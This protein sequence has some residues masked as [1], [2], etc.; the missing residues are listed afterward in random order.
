MV[1]SQTALNGGVAHLS[2]G[3]PVN[4]HSAYAFNFGVFG[5]EGDDH[6]V[7]FEI[8]GSE[9]GA[10]TRTVLAETYEASSF[11]GVVL[12]G[13][14]EIGSVRLTGDVVALNVRDVQFADALPTA[15]PEPATWALML[16]GFGGLGA[17]LRSRRSALSPAQ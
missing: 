5:E 17:A 8:V 1:S 16:L 7:D 11:F 15:V 10:I 2:L 13:G 9:F 4:L 14:G 3:D 6:E 12:S